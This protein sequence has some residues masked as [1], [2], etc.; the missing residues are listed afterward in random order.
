MKSFTSFDEVWSA[1]KEYC[2]ENF[3][4]S[5]YSIWISSIKSAELSH[6]KIILH[7]D[8]EFEAEII[9][10]SCLPLLQE[11][12]LNAAGIANFKI[13]VQ[14]PDWTS[15]EEETAAPQE[16]RTKPAQEEFTKAEP[17]EQ[18]DT[19]TNVPRETSIKNYTFDNFIVGES[20]KFAHSSALRV[21]QSQLGTAYNPLFIYGGSGLGKTHLLFAIQHEMLKNTPSLNILYTTI[22]NFINEFITTIQNKSG[23]AFRQ[24]YRSVDVLIIDDIQFIKKTTGTQDEFFHTFND[25]VSNSKQIV[26][27]S[28]RP[29]RELEGLAD[30]LKTRFSGGLI[31]E[32]SPPDLE[33]RIAIIR[34][35]AKEKG[36]ELTPQE[37]T[38]IA[39]KIRDN[40]RELEG[41]IN[42][43]QVLQ[44]MDD[45]PLTM[46]RIRE[47]IKDIE[48][49][50][51]PIAST[52]E[53]IIE[54]VADMYD[55]TKEELKSD[56]RKSNI[57]MARNIA[58]YVIKE[59]TN[60]S[61][62]SIG[63]MFGGRKHSTVIN[64]I[65]N[66]DHKMKTDP[67]FRTRVYS[68]IKQYK[69]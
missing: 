36:V 27:T 42:K 32:I 6:G 21:A 51:R 39:E 11:A 22:D 57:T 41:A 66:V 60:L 40:V 67:G 26:I 45:A 16:S 53:D 55:L 19:F 52:A 29:P 59:V 10:Q 49:E 3:Q 34:Q 68:L 24:K 46:K 8:T 61:Y 44:S 18:P 54:S 47:V 14:C 38:F 62:E 58:M 30:R 28:D 20:N 63:E 50:S 35:A 64:S 12:F 9:S 7:A 23:E 2:R 15:D 69:K 1:V 65:N 25:L 5:I 31:V 56:K 48:T 4:D 33:T 13:I 17:D 37:Q 43:L